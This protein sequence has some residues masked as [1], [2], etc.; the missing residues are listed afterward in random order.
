MF[1]DNELLKLNTLGGIA[2]NHLYRNDKRVAN[3]IWSALEILQEQLVANN[4]EKKL[5]L[6]AFKKAFGMD[7]EDAF[8][9]FC[10]ACYNTA[11]YFRGLEA[12]DLAEK[13]DLIS[14]REIIEER[15]QLYGHIGEFGK[16][17]KILDR[18]IQEEP[19][20][21]WNYVSYGDLYYLWQVLPEKQNL[22]RAENWYYKA[23]DK[24]LG[25]GTEE[26]EALVERLGDVCVE[27][28]KRSSL[29]KLLE[30]M[31][32]LH[33]GRWMALDEL[34]RTVYIT[35]P[36]SVVL[37]YLQGEISNKTKDINQANEYLDILTDAYNL[38]P[39][40][41]LDGL[42]P[43]Q[44]AEY[45]SQGEHS[46]RII[47]EKM[48]A[49]SKA[50]ESGDLIPPIGAEGSEAF[51]KFQIEFMEGTDFVT[52][53][54]RRDVLRAESRKIEKQIKKGDFIW[55]GFIKFRGMQDISE[56]RNKNLKK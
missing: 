15:A 34:K 53:K 48:E 17:E 25:A 20:N 10:I 49:A 28:L 29:N 35:G 42:C 12:C 21:V 23:F 40:R 6:K 56:I 52:G 39:Q 14:E 9:E 1:N 3:A 16:A 11:Q 2:L 27:R 41:D 44:M 8:N 36:D 30:L 45:Y 43:F 5:L 50:M 31:E 13:F 55:E 46:N 22:Q 19:Q 33:V 4:S 47:M 38:M 32:S 54:R 51:S 26:G 24:G 7:F 37:S 18:L